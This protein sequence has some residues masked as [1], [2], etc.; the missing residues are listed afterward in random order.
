MNL[1]TF[2]IIAVLIISYFC[3]DSLRDIYENFGVYFPFFNISV[4]FDL[5]KYVFIPRFVSVNSAE[6]LFAIEDLEQRNGK[7]SKDLYLS[8]LGKVFDVSSGQSYYGAGQMYH[9]FIGRDASRAFITGDF[10]ESGLT[11]DV[12]DLPLQD[13][14][15]LK[16]WLKMYEDKYKYKG[17]LIGKYYDEEGNPTDYNKKIMERFDEAEEN[18]NSAAKEKEKFPPCNVEWTAEKGS[19]VWCSVR[20]GGIERDWVGVPRKLY[21]PGSNSYRCACI[22]KPV[23]ENNVP[24]G[25]EMSQ[26]ISEYENCDI[27]SYS[28]YVKTS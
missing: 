21:S 28:C 11:D 13:L 14:R 7:N 16:E 17:K 23:S 12:L 25:D 20:S 15:H 4:Y 2:G 10:S 19:R 5:F 22:N 1:V 8:I 24:S 18:E 26:Y 9:G 3:S 6:T 27:N